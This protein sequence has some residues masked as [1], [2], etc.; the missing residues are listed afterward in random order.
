MNRNIE[1]AVGYRMTSHQ[2]D[3][4]TGQSFI[5]DIQEH[6]FV[7]Q[8]LAARKRQL[9]KTMYLMLGQPGIAEVTVLLL[10]ENGFLQPE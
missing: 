10:G 2:T 4:D 7:K 3:K 1:R 6:S 5:S 8:E 9:N